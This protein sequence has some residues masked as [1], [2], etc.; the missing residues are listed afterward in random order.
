M[1]DGIT[2]SDEVFIPFENRRTWQVALN[3]TAA[4]LISIVFLT[5]GL[6]KITDPTGAAARLA[7]ARVPEGLSVP[8]AVGLGIL[9]TFTGVLLFVP[10]FRRWGSWLG[11]LLLFTFM[12]FIAI[13][14][15]ELRGVDCSCFPWLKRAVNP[16]FFAEDGQQLPQ[17]T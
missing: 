6:W 9:E 13:H 8:A 1:A 10:R 3:R 15:N 12:V 7:Q 4:I 11:T 16:A 2:V 14:Y 17:V 5:A